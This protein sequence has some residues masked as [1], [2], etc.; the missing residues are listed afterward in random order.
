MET[1]TDVGM[2]AL[3][4]LP[5]LDEVVGATMSR[6][7][8]AD[9]LISRSAIRLPTLVRT[10]DLVVTH[11]RVGA[12]VAAGRTT[13]I[14]SGQLGEVIDLLNKQSGQRMRGRVVA[15][16]EVEVVY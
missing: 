14:E 16:G 5:T 10:G 4:P 7:L 15:H 9:A 2:V 11:V 13:A 3:A 1:V 8:K 12:V 6:P